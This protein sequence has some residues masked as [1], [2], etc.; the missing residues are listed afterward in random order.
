MCQHQIDREDLK[1]HTGGVTGLKSKGVEE[2]VKPNVVSGSARG[3]SE[4]SIRPAVLSDESGVDVME[5]V[6]PDGSDS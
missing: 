6:S 2:E 3:V 4:S 1:R 5:E